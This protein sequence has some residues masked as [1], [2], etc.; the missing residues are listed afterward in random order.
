MISAIVA[1]AL[2]R[3]GVYDQAF[4]YLLPV[5]VEFDFWCLADIQPRTRLNPGDPDLSHGGASVAGRSV[6]GTK[7]VGC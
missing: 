1:M 6:H 3:T 4:Y 7:T 5:L 2:Q